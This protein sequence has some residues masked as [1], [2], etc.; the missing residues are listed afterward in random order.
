ML[1][2][3]YIRKEL[4]IMD[5][6]KNVTTDIVGDAVTE[7]APATSDNTITGFVVTLTC[8]AVGAAIGIGVWLYKR[9]KDKKAAEL[10]RKKEVE[11]IEEALN[12]FNNNNEPIQPEYAPDED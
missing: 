4:K 6:I 3:F 1:P 10:E 2:K 5:E 12:D 8:T 11:E 7:I 9:H